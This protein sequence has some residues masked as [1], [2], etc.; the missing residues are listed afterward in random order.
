M[1]VVSEKAIPPAVALAIF[2]SLIKV[3]TES[4]TFAGE[5]TVAS[6]P[7]P[8]PPRSKCAGFSRIMIGLVLALAWIR[9]VGFCRT[10]ALRPEDVISPFPP[11]AFPGWCA[12][13]AL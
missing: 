2:F 4:V 10:G 13:P 1:L 3:A 5:R 8:E 12:V 6:T 11:Q 7:A 9:W